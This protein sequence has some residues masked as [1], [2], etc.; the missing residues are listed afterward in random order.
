MYYSLLNLR[1]KKLIPLVAIFPQV[2]K[3]GAKYIEKNCR[4]LLKV[5]VLN[6]KKFTSWILTRAFRMLISVPTT[7]PHP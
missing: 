5:F 7:L 4:T 1:V 6:S 2:N 3:S